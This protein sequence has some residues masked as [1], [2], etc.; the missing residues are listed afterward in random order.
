M[1]MNIDSLILPK[2]QKMVN[3]LREVIKFDSQWEELNNLAYN[4]CLVENWVPLLDGFLKVDMGVRL[5][6]ETKEEAS[7]LGLTQD[8][9]LEETD[10]SKSL[11]LHAADRGKPQLAMLK[12]E[13]S[14]ET[15]YYTLTYN[16]SGFKPNIRFLTDIILTDATELRSS[17]IHFDSESNFD[18][19]FKRVVKFRLGINMSLRTK[20]LMTNEL[21]DDIISDL[22]T[23]RSSSSN[24]LSNLSIDSHIKF[25]LID[26]LYPGRCEVAKS[27][28]GRTLNI[29]MFDFDNAPS[30]E[31]L[32]FNPNAERMLN[33]VSTLPSGLTL[34]SGV[35]G[36]GKGTTLN[37]VGKQMEISGN[38]A[39]AS[40]DDPIEYLRKF[41]Q[42]EYS[43]PKQLHEYIEGMKKMDLNA[44][45]LNEVV[46][47]E[48]AL[49]VYNLV[50]SGVHV[51][52]TIHTNRVFR[53]MYKLEELLGSRYLNI[54]PFLNVISYQDK[55]S[56]T[57]D[58]CIAGM[59]AETYPE[60][61]NERKLLNFLD[62]DLI[63]QPIGCS[64]C[65]HKK[66]KPR[67]IKVVSEH[68]EITDT[69][70][71][72]FLRLNIHEQGELIKEEIKSGENLEN[73]IKL[74][75]QTGTILLSEAIVKLDTWR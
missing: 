21:V 16:R 48:A 22:V 32:G 58:L 15:I 38:F 74:G 50:S 68:L 60:E 71:S 65:N 10:G 5:K 51:L 37:A 29:R 31:Q 66:I 40:L 36:S 28:G 20:Y 26:K 4:E 33:Y 23:N 52:T 8:Y 13:E 42:F 39:I 75:L 14:A 24:K 12:M 3:N 11:Y 55:F 70:K 41:R 19:T 56:I 18:G 49:G 62:L 64:E 34:V 59:S 53:I 1:V 54:I 63:N 43:T 27:I 25:R 6:V 67:G 61:S 7:N 69:L 2:Y 72:K 17:D 35:K 30:I 47:S 46:N 45:Y 73:V 57:C 44:V 9:V